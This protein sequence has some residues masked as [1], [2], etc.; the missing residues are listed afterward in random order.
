MSFFDTKHFGWVHFSQE[1]LHK[2]LWCGPHYSILHGYISLPEEILSCTVYIQNSQPNEY[3]K[4][5]L[6]WKISRKSQQRP[7]PCSINR[8][9]FSSH[10]YVHLNQTIWAFWQ[11]SKQKLYISSIQASMQLNC[12]FPSQFLNVELKPSQP[13]SL[14]K[15]WFGGGK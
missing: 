10:L 3:F 8:S 6:S 12:K 11:R 1:I 13:K 14:V 9:H 7:G 4:L 15:T 5:P 2:V